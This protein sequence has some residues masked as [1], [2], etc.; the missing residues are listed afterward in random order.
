MCEVKIYLHYFACGYSVVPAPFDDK[1]IH[2]PLNDLGILLKIQ[3]TTDTMSSFQYSQF[4]SIGLCLSLCQSHIVLITVALQLNFTVRK[5]QFFYFAS[6]FQRII[7]IIFNIFQ[8]YFSHFRVLLS[9][10]CYFVSFQDFFTSSK[11]SN[12]LAFNYLLYSFVILFIFLMSAVMYLL[13]QLFGNLS[14]VF[15]FLCLYS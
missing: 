13:S 11:L 15:F 9:K 10:F 3:L 4:Y 7:L 2:S 8:Q 5:Y 1:T 12:M 14:I 6:L